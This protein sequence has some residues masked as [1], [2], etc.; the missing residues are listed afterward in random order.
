MDCFPLADWLFTLPAIVT[1]LAGDI[2]SSVMLL[3][4]TVVDEEASKGISWAQYITLGITIAVLVLPFIIGGRL[5][6]ALKMPN[7]GTRFGFV[8]LAIIASAV[9]LFN[10]LPGYGVDLRGGTI[11]VYEIDP[12]KN[13]QAGGDDAAPRIKSEDLVEPLTRRINPSGTQEIVLRPYG[14]SQLEIIIPEVD[15]REVD[16]IKT[17]IEE[18][19]ILRFAILANVTDHKRIIDLATEQA[20][21]DN[22]NE[23]VQDVIFDVDGQIVGRWA[24]VDRE[25][26]KEGKIAPF[27]VNLFGAIVRNPLT[28]ALIQLP[29]S[30][31]GDDG[32]YKQSQWATQQGLPGLETL[33]ITEPLLDVKGEDLAF[34][35]STFDQNGAPAVAFNLTDAGSGKFFALTT[36]NA[37]VGTRS[38]QLGIVLD[39]KLLSAP[40]YSVAHS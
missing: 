1:G 37:P 27:R 7:Y 18:A 15:Q 3:G 9:V 26:V 20:Q 13:V 14:D 25:N 4:Q 28:G 40:E 34:A 35:T 32:E 23:R 30:V 10:R 16:R 5:A 11:L 36:N 33:M 22:P 12:A 17:K 6:K 19:G 24:E 39:D 21:S 8:L 31:F 29:S 38:R 2:T